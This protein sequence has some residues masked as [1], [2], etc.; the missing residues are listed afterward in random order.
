MA[1][2]VMISLHTCHI[3][4]SQVTLEVKDLPANAGDICHVGSIPGSGRSSG[5]RI[6]NL[7]QYSCLETPM[8]RGAWQATVDRVTQNMT[9]AT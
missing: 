3:W 7:L 1:L 6:D 4:A 2:I 9:E 8:N 5:E